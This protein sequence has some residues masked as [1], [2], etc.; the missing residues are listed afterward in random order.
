MRSDVGSDNCCFL[1]LFCRRFFPFPAVFTTVVAVGA[2]ESEMEDAASESPSGLDSLSSVAILKVSNSP[3]DY[4]T[5]NSARN[6]LLVDCQWFFSRKFEQLY[7]LS[8][9]FLISSTASLSLA[10]LCCAFR[11]FCSFFLAFLCLCPRI[12]ACGR[13]TCLC[14][15]SLKRTD[16]LLPSDEPGSSL[17]SGIVSLDRQD[18]VDDCEV[19]TIVSTSDSE[20]HLR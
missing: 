2:E 9:A 4:C 18:E 14:T 3:H 19:P 12:D 8:S 1:F 15:T 17:S 6:Q 16:F 10:L 20:K 13:N 11:L 7:L 5:S